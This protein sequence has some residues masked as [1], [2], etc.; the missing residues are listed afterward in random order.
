M[1]CFMAGALPV[2]HNHIVVNLDRRYTAPPNTRAIQPFCGFVNRHLG[3]R[4]PRTVPAALVKNNPERN[5]CLADPG[6]TYLAYASAGG[7]LVLDLAG[8]KGK[9]QAKWFDP[10]TGKLDRIGDGIVEGGRKVT[11]QSPAGARAWLL[12]LDRTKVSAG[13]GGRRPGALTRGSNPDSRNRLRADHQPEPDER[14]S[15]RV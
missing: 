9:F 10:A 14:R 8:A 2:F 7:P 3:D 5:W 6:R 15:A 1:A 13:Q 11:F 12:W 4:L